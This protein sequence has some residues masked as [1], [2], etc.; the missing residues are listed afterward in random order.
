M[1][2]FALPSFL[3]A[4]AGAAAVGLVINTKPAQ[5]KETAAANDAPARWYKGN[6]H[7]HSL[8]S[9][10]ND[11]P[12]MIVD[13][14]QQRGYNFLAL[15][16]H[17]V[18]HAKEV[19]MAEPT[20]LKRQ[21]SVGKT[22]MAKYLERFGE[23]WV[24]RREKDGVKEVRLKMLEEYRPKF[25]KEGEFLL[26]PAEELSANFAV[27]PE[28]K[29][30][31]HMVAFNLK[32]EVKPI[33]G[34]SFRDVMRK[35]L[36]AIREQEKRTGQ[37]ML[38]HI[39]HP[40]FRWALTAE[41]LAEVLEEDFFEIYNGHPT[42][43]Y[44]GDATRYGHEM[45]WDIANTLRLTTLDAPPL[46]GVGTDDAH[47]YH[48]EDSA[49]GRGWVMVR[50]KSLKPEALISAMRAGDFYASS[51]VTLQEVQ[52]KDGK[53]TIRIQGE[54]GVT[55]TTKIVGTPKKYDTSVSEQPTNAE[56]DPQPVRKVYSADIGKTFATFTSETIEY[57]LTGDEL[58][59]RAVITSTKPPV[60]PS[61]ENQLQMAWTQPVGWKVKSNATTGR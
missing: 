32:E 37:P 11:F 41:D 59:V 4:A 61:Y 6:T 43:N 25:E 38:T 5:A 26:V 23:T 56:K 58:Y 52:F 17:N 8:W 1:P 35:N 36:Q 42:I 9:D 53:L 49:P 27:T 55:Y 18:L 47:H 7:T 57:K 22:A 29:A 10:G 24:E 13:W 60:N 44:L 39:N 46:Y 54:P 28:L 3:L 50:S 15:S 34:T 51:G 16:D 31:I 20:I 21:K 45:L 2:R 33:E 12:E 40:N 48:G 19:W 30:P 14:Y